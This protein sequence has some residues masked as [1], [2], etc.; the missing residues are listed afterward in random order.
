MNRKPKKAQPSRKPPRDSGQRFVVT[1]DDLE[2]APPKNP[3]EKQPHARP[4]PD[5]HR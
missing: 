5:R 1:A 2:I 3:P 4:R